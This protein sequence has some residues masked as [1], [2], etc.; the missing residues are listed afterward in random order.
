MKKRFFEL[1][2]KVS[3]NSTS[4]PRLGCVVVQKNRVISVGFNNMK[5]THPKSTHPFHTLH[6]E[7]HALL[8]S[9]FEETKG[10]VAYIYR[11]LKDGTM[12]L[13]KPCPS[14]QLALVYAGISK[15]YYTSSEGFLE[16]SLEQ[17]NRR[18]RPSL[19]KFK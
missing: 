19:Q 4:E 15:A 2:K 14:C 6:A 18:I 13:A 8:G 17:A 10:A 7:V 9:S 1:A 5:K 12:A 3:L 16:M 11:E